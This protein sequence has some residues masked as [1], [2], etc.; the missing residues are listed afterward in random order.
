M[1][2]QE[3]KKQDTGAGS[4]NIQPDESEFLNAVQDAAPDQM[5]VSTT[6]KGD[7]Q[8]NVVNA[9]NANGVVSGRKVV[10]FIWQRIAICAMVI[11]GGLICAIIV[12]VIIMNNINVANAK[13]EATAKATDSKLKE[14][15]A[16]LDAADQSEAMTAAG[17][18]EILTG[19]DIL[20]IH[21]LLV[22]KYGSVSSIDPAG[23]SV[24][25]I[26]V[27]KTFKVASFRMKNAAGTFR[28]IVYA[29][30]ADNEWK[31]ANYD[32]DNEKNPCKNT[33]D[34]EKNALAGI[35]K[36]P[37]IVSDEEDEEE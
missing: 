32:F 16:V 11:G 2:P 20:Q 26:K 4:P 10:D 8:M 7:V 34:E 31:V 33:S 21:N 3:Q 5:D 12:L 23:V 28:T 30:M 14:I 25:L 6:T 19:N 37:A 35:V 18:D 15:Y 9:I 27:N 29:K 1:N 13:Q 22:K 36:C 24:N 17:Q